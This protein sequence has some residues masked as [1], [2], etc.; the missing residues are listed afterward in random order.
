MK[1]LIKKMELLSDWLPHDAYTHG[2]CV[3]KFLNWE[4]VEKFGC[5]E[6]SISSN[7]HTFTH[8]NIYNYCIIKKGT[9]Y[10]TVGFNENSS[11]GW[12]FPVKSIRR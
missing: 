1:I 11:I 3:E 4:V 8:K 2:L 10:K 9:K 6:K 12:S 7:P 5:G